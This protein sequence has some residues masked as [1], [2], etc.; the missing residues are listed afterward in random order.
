MDDGGMDAW[1]GCSQLVKRRKIDKGVR[2]G[3]SNKTRRLTSNTGQSIKGCAILFSGEGGTSDFFSR[4]KTEKKP[5]TERQQTK[6]N[7][8]T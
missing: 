4:R 3:L 5:A 7:K 8:N 2:G 6:Q 1:Q